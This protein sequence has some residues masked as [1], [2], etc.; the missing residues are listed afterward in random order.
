MPTSFTTN[1]PHNAVGLDTAGLGGGL[2]GGVEPHFC[3]FLWSTMTILSDGNVTCG[4]DDPH[5]VRS[6]GNIHASSI[7]DIWSGQAYVDLRNRLLSGK[8]CAGCQLYTPV[9]ENGLVA[10]SSA[11]DAASPIERPVPVGDPRMPYPDR[12]I[13]EPTI[14][15][16]LR[17]NQPVCNINY[18]DG[19]KPRAIP[20]MSYETFVRIMDELG[21][22]LKFMYFFNYGDP[23]VNARAEDMLIYAKRINPALEIVTS[24][25]GI[26]L[27]KEERAQK[28]VESG[29]DSITFTIGGARQDS[30]ER[31][32]VRGKLELALRGMENIC[33]IKKR[34]GV[35]KPEV[36]WRYLTFNWNDSDAEIDEAMTIANRMGVDKLRFHLTREPAGSA[37][38]IRAPDQ[39]GH[40]KIRALADYAFG[41]HFGQPR[42]TGMYQWEQDPT[43]GA[44]RWS[45]QRATLTFSTREAW[46]SIAAAT[47][48][49]GFDERRP[50]LTFRGA[51]GKRLGRPGFNTWQLIYLPVPEDYRDGRQFEVV[52]E[53]DEPWRPR[54][55]GFNTDERLLGV[56]VRPGI[57]DDPN[58]QGF[59]RDGIDRHGLYPTV[60]I[61]PSRRPGRWSAPLARLD[62]PQQDGRLVLSLAAPPRRFENNPTS[63]TLRTPWAVITA[64]LEPW[65]WTSVCIDVPVDYRAEPDIAVRLS[66]THVWRPEDDGI[67]DD[68]DL[69]VMIEWQDPSRSGWQN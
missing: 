47:N 3:T 25:N 60:S 68:R 32:H 58:L 45:A 65:T 43:L 35:A 53:V 57:D 8:L 59:S 37:S 16:N 56:M 33:R 67:R 39:P 63:V 42:S 13:L 9:A 46:V 28:V 11:S 29:L 12:L 49:P 44:M 22:H 26:P 4:L 38:I 61:G 69:G 52:M 34:L 6:F 2:V 64:Q 54:D 24:T 7:R 14:A 20:T 21:P 41:Y 10:R 36:T 50:T 31:Y 30:Y 66:V 40:E 27:M 5:G 23:F 55:V 15:C 19:F 17:C 62:I 51:F 48:G 18:A 1:R